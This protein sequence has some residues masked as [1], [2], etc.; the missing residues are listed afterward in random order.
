MSTGASLPSQ[1]TTAY[2]L[3]TASLDQAQSS[4]LGS[5]QSLSALQPQASST[6]SQI[7]STASS[8]LPQVQT[9]L[10]AAAFNPNLYAQ[11]Y[12]QQ[13]DQTNATLSQQGMAGSP[14]GA[15]LAAQQNQNFNNTWNQQQVGLESTAAST[16]EGLLGSA[17]TNAQSGLS[18][19]TGITQQQIQDYLSYLGAGSSATQAATGQYG[20]E[21]SAAIGNQQ[22]ANQTN[23][24]IGNL[25]GTGAKAVGS[26]L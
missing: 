13:Q 11:Q 25:L 1:P 26:L 24:G 18:T 8:L 4:A 2:Q 20:T 12:Q 15:G 16:A 23:L 10:N 22:L 6:G 21:S 19:A 5:T 7:M 9:A 14:Y 17:A 3:P